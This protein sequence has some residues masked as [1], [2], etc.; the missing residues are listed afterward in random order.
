MNIIITFENNL[1]FLSATGSFLF[2]TVLYYIAFIVFAGLAFYNM[3]M[4]YGKDDNIKI[5]FTKLSLVDTLIF[6]ITL[7][8][9]LFSLF[10]LLYSIS[11][12]TLSIK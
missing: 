11:Y 4:N 10:C 5:P 9:L 2:Y 6:V 12:G 7:L 8:I 3:K 1:S